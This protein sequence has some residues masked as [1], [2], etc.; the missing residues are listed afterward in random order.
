M[1]K[2]NR[3]I[4]PYSKAKNPLKTRVIRERLQEKEGC[5]GI[6]YPDDND[7]IK[8]VYI[9]PRLSPKDYLDTLI[10]ETIHHCVPKLSENKVL[11]TSTTIANLL[12]RLGYRKK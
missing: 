12:W 11:N 7:E 10:H 4:K 1:R 5:V 6:C 9:D 3:Y 8:T 2:R